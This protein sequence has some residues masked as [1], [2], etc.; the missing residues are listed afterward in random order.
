MKKFRDFSITRKLL[1]GFLSMVL[2]VLLTAAMGIFGMV[3][4][5]QMDQKLYEVQ[6]A[7]IA[8]LINATKSLY[9]I[10]VDSRAAVINAGDLE[11]IKGYEESYL[12]SKENFLTESAA[13]RGSISTPDSLVLF[14]E[15][16]EIFIND[17]D[18]VIQKTYELAKTGNQAAADAAGAKATDKIQ[19]LFANYDQLI[20]NRMAA[21]KKTSDTNIST[22][23]ILISVLV[24]LGIVGS[25]AAVFLGLRISR[26]ISKPIGKVVAAANEIARGHVDID[27]EEIKSQDETGRL[28][29]AFNEMLDSIR[30][31]TE[32]AESISNGDFTQAVP[33][34]SDKDV[35]GIALQKIQKGLNRTLLLISSAAEQVNSGASQVSSASQALASGAA[36]QAATVEEL[37][38]SITTVAK[39]A[40]DNAVSVKQATEYV[41]RSVDGVK[42]GNGQMESLIKAMEEIRTASEKISDITK[43]IEDIAFQT[44]ILALNAAIEA[45]RAGTAGKGFAVVADE[46]R[47][48]AAKSAEAAKQTAALIHN[49]SSTVEEGDKLAAKTAQILREVAKQ[50]ELVNNTIHQIELASTEQA[51]AIEQITQGL[52]QVSSV[53]QTNAA[54]AEESSAS[55]E[56]LAAQAQ[57]LRGEVAKFKLAA[58]A[59][60]GKGLPLSVFPSGETGKPELRRFIP[61]FSSGG[62]KY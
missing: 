20:V 55:S 30:K 42:E 49:S 46:V 8:H 44:N 35:L 14:D 15:A 54:T 16:A 2:V 53:V 21:A 17:F 12:S 37:S 57:T 11:K 3:K 6:T 27:L 28:A 40:E 61:A 39:Q 29:A 60:E 5:S 56:E 47:N 23:T 9:Q 50:A 7:P 38:A 41:V 34:R 31:Q 1:T 48:L 36:E 43:V 25:G 58:E 4:I 33:L 62:S 22:A 18:P 45:A 32:L 19:E 51:G 13:Y 24:A 59:E 10:R 26:M 52:T